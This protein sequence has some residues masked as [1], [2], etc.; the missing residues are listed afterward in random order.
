M[1]HDF[2]NAITAVPHARRLPLLLTVC[3]I[4]CLSAPATAAD[5]APA[6]LAPQQERITDDAIYR[7]HGVYRET[8]QRIKALN[9]AGV[10]VADYQLSKAQCWLDASF[11]EYSR[12]DRG[13]FPQAALEESQRI[14]DALEKKQDPG[15]ETPLVNKAEKLRPDLWARQEAL[16]QHPGFRCAA[17]QTACAEVELVHAGNEIHDAG[18]RHAKPY[19]QIA[20]DLTGGAEQAAEECPA[21]A[22][23]P[24]PPAP[25][26]RVTLSADALFAFDRSSPTDLLP[27][28][29]AELDQLAR[30]IG[31]DRYAV[32]SLT[33]IGHTD[34][35]GSASYNQ[36]LSQARADTVKAYLQQH[37]VTVPIAAE[38][39]G[40][41]QQVAACE[42]VT[43]RAALIDCLQPN[44]RVE[45]VVEAEQRR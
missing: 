39:R 11:H 10:R 43:P 25:P 12:N 30:Q 24:V 14:L 20:E 3:A 16:K 6:A 29:R 45:V 8:Q 37:G 40:S 28:G 23:A 5:P 38:G 17:Q 9:D 4:M 7:D 15:M 33:V 34:R 2:S 41:Q 18:W 19:V 31:D 32:R 27:K 44:R 26:A 21:P 1:N 42:G 35:L 36:R 13:G 22:P